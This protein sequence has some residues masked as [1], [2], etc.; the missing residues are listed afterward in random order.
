VRE[1][2]IRLD[3]PFYAAPRGPARLTPAQQ[4][5]IFSYFFYISGRAVR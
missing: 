3:P 2:T 4:F 5:F 1:A